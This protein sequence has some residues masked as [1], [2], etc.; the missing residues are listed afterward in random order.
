MTIKREKVG[1]NLTRTTNMKTGT[2]RYTHSIKTGAS[3]RTSQSWSS[4]GNTRRTSTTNVGG[5]VTRKQTSSSPKKYKSSS[6]T[7]KSG[8]SRRQSKLDKTVDKWFVI[9]LVIVFVVQW[10][11]EW[12]M[13]NPLYFAIFVGII[14][15]ALIYWIRVKFDI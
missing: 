14:T 11:I 2:T 3:T 12:F 1:K 9:I 15:T 13:A 5:Q 4:N 6:G 7:R 8:G 10:I